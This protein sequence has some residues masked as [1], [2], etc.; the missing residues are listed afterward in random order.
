[1]EYFGFLFV[2]LCIGGGAAWLI[3]KARLL[4][5]TAQAKGESQIEIARL[6]AE[7]RQTEQRM[8]EVARTYAETLRKSQNAAKVKENKLHNDIVSGKLRLFVPVKAPECA[9][10]AATDTAIAAG[11][12]GGAPSA[13]LD[14]ETA[15]ALVAIAEE[16]DRAITKLNACITLYN[17][18]RSA[19]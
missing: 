4:A 10:P 8:G 7:A 11:D 19:Q 2:G 18:A 16:G 17:N 5:V 1:M 12:S 15:K 13:E 6:N 3:L 14:R 9:I